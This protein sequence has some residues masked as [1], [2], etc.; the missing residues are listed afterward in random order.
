M[1]ASDTKGK[2]VNFAEAPVPTT[3]K[4]K[5]SPGFT[6]SVTVT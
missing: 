2:T 3:P 5:A 4:D 1:K 6:T